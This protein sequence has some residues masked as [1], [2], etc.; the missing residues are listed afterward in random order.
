MAQ[1]N[2]EIGLDRRVREGSLAG[3]KEAS[4]TPEKTVEAKELKA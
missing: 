4:E 1:I 2:V 3:S